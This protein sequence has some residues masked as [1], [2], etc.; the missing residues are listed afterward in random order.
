MTTRH[1]IAKKRL[2]VAPALT[3]DFEEHVS[4]AAPRLTWI[5]PAD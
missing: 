3:A 1:I 5:K 4:D 2:H